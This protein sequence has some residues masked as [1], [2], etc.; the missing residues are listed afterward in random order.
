MSQ[1]NR[2]R[3]LTIACA[4]AGLLS[5]GAASA[6]VVELLP[7]LEPFIASDIQLVDRGSG[8]EL[9]FTT[10]S[11]NRGVGTLEVRG[12]AVSG[13]RRDVNQRVFKSDGTYTDYLVG[14]FVYHDDHNHFHLEDCA[15]YTL[16]PVNAPGASQLTGSKVSFCLIDNVKVNRRLPNAPKKAVYVTCNPDVQGI[17]VGWGDRYG[18]HLAGQSLPFGNNPSG[19]Y[20]LKNEVNPGSLGLRESNPS[21]NV[22]CAVLRIDV[23]TRSV[24][25]IGTDCAPGSPV[26]ISSMTPGSVTPGFPVNVTI[27]GSGF[28]P[29]TSVTFENGSGK[30]PVASNVQVSADGKTITA[31]VTVQNGGSPN[32]PF[33]DLRVD[34]AVLP[35]ALEV[36]R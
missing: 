24:Q 36:V 30:T 9:I 27:T 14:S 32:D 11:W 21:N 35:D 10:T 12:G 26:T 5:A 31:T 25:V 18:S 3:G 19:D 29:G 4:I 22:S 17:S 16:Q 13:D 34:S 8:L 28:V 20:L 1:R 33:W 15:H 6:Q 23:S 2:V 7:D